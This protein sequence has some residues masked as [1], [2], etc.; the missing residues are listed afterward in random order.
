MRRCRIHG[1]NIVSFPPLLPSL[2]LTFQIPLTRNHA[3]V[4]NDNKHAGACKSTMYGAS[5]TNNIWNS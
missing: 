3:V 5:V 1:D 2:I 4:N